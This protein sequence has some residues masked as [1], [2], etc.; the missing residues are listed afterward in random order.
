[1]TFILIIICIII[2]FFYI[3]QKRKNNKSV[4]TQDPFDAFEQYEFSETKQTSAIEPPENNTDIWNDDS[5]E[6]NIKP[7]RFYKKHPIKKGKI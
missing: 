7:I 4:Q 3:R 1:M 5:R 6:L 2:L